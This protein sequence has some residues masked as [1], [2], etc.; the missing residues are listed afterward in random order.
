MSLSD[1]METGSSDR[2]KAALC[3]AEFDSFEHLHSHIGPRTDPQLFFPQL[4]FLH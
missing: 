2:C 1:I 3:G 4:R